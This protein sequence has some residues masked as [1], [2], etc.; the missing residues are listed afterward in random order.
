MASFNI[1]Q[2]CTFFDDRGGV[3][4]AAR[5]LAL[6]QAKA[7]YAVTVLCT[8]PGSGEEVD[9]QGLHIIRAGGPLT[10]ADRPLSWDF[11]TRL[12]HVKTDVLHYHLP[13]PLG[14]LG[15]LLA[16][17]QAKAVVAT[18]HHDIG[19]Y[20]R[21]NTA[22][23]GLLQQFLKATDRILVTAEPLINQIPNHAAFKHK[24]SV[25]PLGIDHHPFEEPVDPSSIK[26]QYRGPIVLFVGRLV[27]YKGIEVLLEAFRHVRA[28]LV[29][30]GEG[31]LRPSLEQLI[32]RQGLSDKVHLLGRVPDEELRKLYAAC[33][34]FVL[35]STVSTE[36]F[37]LVQVEAMLAGKPVIN[38]NLPTGVPTVS[39]HG[40]TGLTVDPKSVQQLYEAL[41]TLISDNQ[42]RL[43]YGA[44]A[45]KR[46]L[47]NFTL[48]RH[49]QS[50]QQVYDEILALKNAASS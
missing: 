42:L 10:I 2:V 21:F 43:T 45:R 35:P 46:A 23:Q 3:E 50:V 19:R 30:V 8:K 39:I 22:Y 29:V 11:V 9:E 48:E 20:P 38:T 27:Y 17:P 41:A 40:E 16:K 26:A 32:R 1:T 28:H 5:D 13:F 4:K 49:T 7:G 44:N 12:S 15:H 36:C 18:W 34:I 24:I 47:A 6:M 37:G 25:V 14:T 33:D 31:P